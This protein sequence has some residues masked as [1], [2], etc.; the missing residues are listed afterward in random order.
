MS[1]FGFLRKNQQEAKVREK[2]EIIKYITKALKNIREEDQCKRL[3][4][5]A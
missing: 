4:D 1:P 2:A 5:L 3:N